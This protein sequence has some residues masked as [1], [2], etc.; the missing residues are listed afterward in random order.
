MPAIIGFLQEGKA[1]K[2]MDSKCLMLA[3][4]AAVIRVVPASVRDP[5]T[6]V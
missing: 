2:A 1:E 5:L 3:L 6:A 4:R